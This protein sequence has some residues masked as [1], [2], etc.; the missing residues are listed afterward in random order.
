MRHH[1]LRLLVMALAVT[2]ALGAATPKDRAT[3]RRPQAIPAPADNAPLPARVALGKM[4]F[5]DPRLSGSGWISCASCHNPAFDWTDGLPTALGDG[6]NRLPRATPTL[7][8]VA[9]DTIFMWDGRAPTL[10]AQALGPIT[11]KGEMDQ[12]LDSLVSKL[13]SI[14]G[15]RALFAR[16]YPN[17]PISGTTVAKAIASFERTLVATESPFD[18]WLDGDDAAMSDSAQRGFALFKGKAQCATCHEGF[19][20]T[21]NGFHNIGVKTLPGGKP[22][23]GRYAQRPVKSMKGAF[24]TPTLRDVALTAPYMHN[25]A[26]TTLA[27]V[28]DHYDRGGG[29]AD[30][31]DPNMK[32]LHLTAREKRDLVAFLR[33]LTGAPRAVT[34]PQLPQ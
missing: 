24:K 8:N 9:Y 12:N 2:G 14:A 26:Y 33:S 17:E 15:Y 18:R 6:M 1:G 7:V 21:D 34:V 28:I 11:A 32:P 16:A 29:D 3:Y 22:D 10:E 4:L 19:N 25:G 13:R 23:I 20:F 30:D 27:E 5:F 31:L